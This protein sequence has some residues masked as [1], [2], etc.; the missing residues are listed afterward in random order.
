MSQPRSEPGPPRLE[1][2]KIAKSYSNCVLIATRN[3]YMSRRQTIASYILLSFFSPIKKVHQ[4][5]KGWRRVE[6]GEGIVEKG[7]RKSENHFVY[8][9]WESRMG[10][11]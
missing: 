2:S 4:K 8:G 1:A 6:K 11:K 10:N 7:K 3:I 9:N 5:E